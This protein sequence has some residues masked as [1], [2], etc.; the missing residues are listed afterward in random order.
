MYKRL[1]TS[2]L[3]LGLA[4]ILWLP[5]A[6]QSQQVGPGYNGFDTVTTGSSVTMFD[7][8]PWEGVPIAHTGF[9]NFG[10]SIGVQNIG[11]TDTIIQRVGSPVTAP[12]GTIGLSVDALQLETV[13]PVSLGGGP[14]G[15]YFVTLDTSAP[16]TGQ[17]TITS[18]PNAGSPGTFSDYFTVNF[19]IRY[20]SLTG[21]IVAPEQT[22]TLTASGDWQTTPPP[23]GAPPIMH[24][25]GGP[26]NDWH[27]VTG[28]PDFENDPALIDP[29]SSIPGDEAFQPFGVPETFSTLALLGLGTVCLLAGER[30][31][32]TAKA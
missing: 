22:L 7:G 23:S 9:Y 5:S 26:P 10:G 25:T 15:N 4:G 13:T 12:G 21:P 2:P 27:V 20:G 19:D 14:V 32:P 11:N 3:A 8:I 16:N 28:D 30:R 18:F 1:M 31:C 6:L 17:L 29:D 24:Q